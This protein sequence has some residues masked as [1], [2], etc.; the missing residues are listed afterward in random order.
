MFKPG[1]QVEI[2]GVTMLGGATV[3]GEVVSAVNHRQ[4]WDDEDDWYIELQTETQGAMYWK[5]SL[6][7]GTVRGV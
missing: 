7:G 3:T 4:P 2:S 1:D 5:Q 6:D